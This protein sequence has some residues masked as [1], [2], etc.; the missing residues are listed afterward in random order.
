MRG[1]ATDHYRPDGVEI[2]RRGE[3][4]GGGPDPAEGKLSRKPVRKVR[5]RCLREKALTGL[6]GREKG[7]GL[8]QTGGGVALGSLLGRKGLAEAGGR[9]W[10]WKS[11]AWDMGGVQLLRG[12]IRV[13][14]RNGEVCGRC[15]SYGNGSQSSTGLSLVLRICQSMVVRRSWEDSKLQGSL[16]YVCLKPS[17]DWLGAWLRGRVTA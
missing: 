12:C 6:L 7:T 14:G 15:Q 13:V 17:S 4:E 16:L 9:F 3:E 10:D 8:V 1:S 11:S 2:K 5:R